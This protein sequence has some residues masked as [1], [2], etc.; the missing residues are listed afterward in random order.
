MKLYCHPGST[1]SRPVML[2]AAEERV[3]LDMQIVDLFTGEQYQST[4]ESVNPNHLVPVLEDDGQVL[5]DSLR[6]VAHLEERHP[7]APL[8]PGEPARREEV[9]VFLDWFDRVWKRPPNLLAGALEAGRDPEE[10][11]LA[12]WA[13]ELRG[14]LDRFEALLKERDFLLGQAFGVGDL[15]VFPF[16]KYGVVLNDEDD[17]LFHRILVEHLRPEARHHRLRAWIERVDALPRAGMA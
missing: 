16:L 12:A 9:H 10:P 7:Q 6:I 8:Y 5:A 17:E 2:F 1:T 15:A 3:A 11:D 4:Y 13:A 14:S